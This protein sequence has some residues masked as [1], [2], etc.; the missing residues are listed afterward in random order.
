MNENEKPSIILL[1]E[2]L[3]AGIVAELEDG[4]QWGDLIDILPRVSLIV[5]EVAKLNSFTDREQRL[6]LVELICYIVDHTDAWGPDGVI[7]PVVKTLART[8]LL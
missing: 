8:F 2:E 6:L 3:G 7:D 1:I 5:A 4:F